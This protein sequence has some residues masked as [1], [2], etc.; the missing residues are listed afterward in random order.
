M[1]CY[2]CRWENAQH[3]PRC[4]RTLDHPEVKARFERGYRD[5]WKGKSDPESD[6]DPVYALGWVKGDIASDNWWNS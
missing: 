3:D 2:I 6:R 5:G 1:R 4:P